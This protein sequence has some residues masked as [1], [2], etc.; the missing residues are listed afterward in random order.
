[1]MQLLLLRH[2]VGNAQFHPLENAGSGFPDMLRGYIAGWWIGAP[3]TKDR[4][5]S[6]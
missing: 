5:L 3:R 6:P 4:F 2:N 1:M